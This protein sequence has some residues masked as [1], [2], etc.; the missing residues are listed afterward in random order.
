[1]RCVQVYPRRPDTGE[2]DCVDIAGIVYCLSRGP[3]AGV[4]KGV[5][6]RGWFCGA[7]RGS[8][9]GERVCI[10]YDPDIPDQRH[11]FRCSFEYPQ[12]RAER[13]CARVDVP[14]AGGTCEAGGECPAAMKCVAGYCLPPQPQPEC[15]LDK[16]CAAGPC[17][18]GTCVEAPR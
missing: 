12:G 5:P 9:T 14:R 6:D 3:A 17:R 11:A 15:W 13:V 2:W 7:R 18:Y 16:D 4:P 8:T 10:D 1:M